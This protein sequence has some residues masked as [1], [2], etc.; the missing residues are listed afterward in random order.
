MKNKI[1][2]GIITCNRP[3]F[4]SKCI[5]SIP[6]VDEIVVVNDGIPYENDLYPK[7]ITRI[8]QHNKNRGI[9]VTKNDALKFLIE[10]NCNHIFLVEDDIYI[11]DENI[12]TDYIK[13]G[14]YSGIFHFNYGYHGPLNRNSLGK[15]TF[16]KEITYKNG[17]KVI[18][19]S[20]LTGALSYYKDIVIKK[21]GLMDTFYKNVLEHV[22]HTYR[23]IREGFHPP[24]FWFAD[25]QNSYSKIGEQDE[26][27][28]ES[29]LR[30]N[31]ITFKIRA[32]LFN[33][34]FKLKFGHK[35]EN[36]PLVEEDDVIIIL[37]KLIN[38]KNNKIVII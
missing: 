9:S 5:N 27:L 4:F 31:I 16:K 3:I 36:I 8:I 25:V 1:G 34:Y 10:T 30:K 38:N 2:I 6:K 37:N 32:H 33:Y 26:F 18:L 22:D 13:A 35:P 15:P 11:K 28:S 7:H 21:I 29:I 23:I 17:I 19:N 14:E 20:K 12:F 24:F